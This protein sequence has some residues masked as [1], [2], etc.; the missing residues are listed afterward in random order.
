M[1]STFGLLGTILVWATCKQPLYIWPGKPQFFG[2]M[3]Q[4]VRQV[5]NEKMVSKPSLASFSPQLQAA[6]VFSLMNLIFSIP[7]WAYIRRAVNDVRD[8]DPAS[9]TSY[10][11]GFKT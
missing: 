2:G 10:A 9:D 1:V 5:G 6:S 3:P 8:M 7:S 4:S 11:Y